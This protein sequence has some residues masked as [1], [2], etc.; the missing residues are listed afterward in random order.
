MCSCV[1]L[2]N[3]VR[4][5]A[6]VVVWLL[7]IGVGQGRTHFFGMLDT[8]GA[9]TQQAVDVWSE[10]RA[11]EAGPAF[12]EEVARQ[13]LLADTLYHAVVDFQLIKSGQ[14]VDA[15]H[16]TAKTEGALRW[17]IDLWFCI[18]TIRCIPMRQPR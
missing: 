17:R 18:Q 3:A 12:E 7:V 5:E 10:F 1:A 2:S 8:G 14:A 9:L 11:V 16:S 6:E 4:D 15:T 13:R